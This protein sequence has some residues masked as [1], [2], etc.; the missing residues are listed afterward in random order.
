MP[1]PVGNVMMTS[2]RITVP[3]TRIGGMT[4]ASN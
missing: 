2:F 3:M 1:Q 4:H